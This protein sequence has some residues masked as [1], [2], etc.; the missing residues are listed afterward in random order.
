MRPIP[1]IAVDF[2]RS[3][4]GVRKTAYQDSVGVWTIG[5]GSTSNVT[6]GLTIT[7]AE[8]DE[9][10]AADLQTA[11]WRLQA[12][13]GPIMDGL[14]DNKFAALLSFVFN[15]GARESWTIWKVIRA[16]RFADV[17]TE[18]RKF[19]YAGGKKLNGLIN[20]REHEA[21]LWMIDVKTPAPIVIGPL[22]PVLAAAP[23]ATAAVAAH[24]SFAPIVISIAVSLIVAGLAYVIF[25]SIRNHRMAVSQ[26]FQDA[27]TAL[28]GA[29]QAQE[30][31]SNA[32]LQAQVTDLTNQLATANAAAAQVDTDDTAA[33]VAAT[34][35]APEPAPPQ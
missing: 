27:L 1:Q 20:R 25:I 2:I 18:L 28:V 31:A 34:P 21:E 8:I 4:E 17:P 15:V 33:V 11:A 10:L 12:R 14:S 3:L 6:P 16:K 7:D 35:V 23:I 5:V 22:A 9:R 30:A 24:P 29:F 13:I 26:S 19:V 32:A